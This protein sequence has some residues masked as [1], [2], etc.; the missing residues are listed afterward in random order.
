MTQAR[1]MTKALVAPPGIPQ[2]R[3]TALR[4]AILD[5]THNTAFIADAK[6]QRLDVAPGSWEKIQKLMRDTVH[7][8]PAVV[9][10][11]RKMTAG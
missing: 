7:T 2:T 8:D 1:N 3:A 6:R 10:L 4:K 9:K 11:T 5:M